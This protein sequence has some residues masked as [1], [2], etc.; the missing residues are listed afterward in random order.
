MNSNHNPYHY[1]SKE[2][3][4]L[5]NETVQEIVVY[6]PL[7]NGFCDQCN[8]KDMLEDEKRCQ[9]MRIGISNVMC[10]QVKECKVFSRKE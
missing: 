3:E 7:I 4:K 9:K 2:D 10:S 6:N 5:M 8:N 1:K